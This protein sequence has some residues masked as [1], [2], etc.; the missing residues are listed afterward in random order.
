MDGDILRT[1]ASVR[2]RRLVARLWADVNDAIASEVER[3]EERA[4]IDVESR[5]RNR[6]LRS[7]L[8]WPFWLTS[9]ITG[10]SLTDSSDTV[11]VRVVVIDSSTCSNC[12]RK[13]VPVFEW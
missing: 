2:P 7:G 12:L 1:D 9:V 3:V 11:K 4:A 5:H 6:H 13:I 10:A 8:D